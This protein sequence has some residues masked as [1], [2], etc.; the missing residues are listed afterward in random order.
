MK[1]LESQTLVET[2]KFNNLYIKCFQVV[3]EGGGITGAKIIRTG[4]S[5]VT[6]QVHTHMQYIYLIILQQ[7]TY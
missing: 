7:I 1:W 4:P 5:S 3:S 2:K 6:G